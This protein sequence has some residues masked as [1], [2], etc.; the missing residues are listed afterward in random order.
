[1]IFDAFQSHHFSLGRFSSENGDILV[2]RRTSRHFLTLS[3]PGC[4]RKVD[5]DVGFL[6]IESWGGLR[7]SKLLMPLGFAISTAARLTRLFT[8]VIEMDG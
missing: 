2:S 3:G 8:D 4:R 1:M 7:M 5:F 6:V